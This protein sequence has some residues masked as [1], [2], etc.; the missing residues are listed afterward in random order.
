M[1]IQL[2]LTLSTL[3]DWKLWHYSNGKNIE[4]LTN[5][6]LTTQVFIWSSAT[7]RDEMVVTDDNYM[8]FSCQQTDSPSTYILVA[9][10][11]YC[12]TC[13][14]FVK[15]EMQISVAIDCINVAVFL[16]TSI[17]VMPS[18]FYRHI[19]IQT[20]HNIAYLVTQLTDFMLLFKVTVCRQSVTP[21]SKFAHES[22][23]SIFRFNPCNNPIQSCQEW[24]IT[25]KKH[26]S[27]RTM[28]LYFQI[29][30][31]STTDW[32]KDRNLE[33]SSI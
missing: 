9:N 19:L 18:S 29:S 7:H 32:K 15:D 33:W 25:T 30:I 14:V 16:S 17:T 12:L 31:A 5:T 13:F 1:T 26:A 3:T 22:L 27:T 24:K 8:Q 28:S 2:G 23:R 10:T 21:S 4:R 11:L 6:S 20:Q